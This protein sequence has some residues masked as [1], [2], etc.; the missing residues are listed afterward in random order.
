[1]RRVLFRSSGNIGSKDLNYLQYNI[2]S[3]SHNR[4]IGLIYLASQYKI[5]SNNSNQQPRKGHDHKNGSSNKNDSINDPNNRTT[6]I[7]TDS[8]FTLSKETKNQIKAIST[9]A[10]SIPNMITI[11]RICSTPILCNLIITERYQL[12][13]AGCFIA[14]FSDWLDGYI[15]KNY[16]Q[17]TVFGTYLDPLA[18]KILINSISFSLSYVDILPWW[19]SGLWFGRDLLLVGMSYR[20]AAIAARGRGHAVAD[21][22]QTPLKVSP[23]MISKVNT[24]FQFG[25]IGVALSLGAVGE[26]GYSLSLGYATFGL[27]ESL[28]YVTASTT[29]LSGLSYVDGKS[30]I[31]S[32]NSKDEEI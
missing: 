22:S 15:A 11:A 10:K 24:L 20:L 6:T 27:V 31:K 21:P 18:D 1:M 14:G 7:K 8:F 12:A 19:S 5:Y 17:S 30:M 2:N 13:V 16:N 3:F 32:G 4:E 23:T 25:T 26:I 9:Q 28:T 29:I